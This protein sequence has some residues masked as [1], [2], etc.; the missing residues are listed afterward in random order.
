MDPGM[1]CAGPFLMKT[2]LVLDMSRGPSWA[3]TWESEP[4]R[5]LRSGELGR[6]TGW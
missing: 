3:Y 5:G 6:E 1:R 4:F 2:G